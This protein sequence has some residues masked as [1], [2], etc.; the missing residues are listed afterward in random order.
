M[1][2]IIITAILTFNNIINQT[3]APIF[4]NSTITEILSPRLNVS[5]I[6]KREKHKIG[7]DFSI[8][9]QKDNTK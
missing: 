2:R 6:R 1:I 7:S 3:N 9:K 4:T 5:K 8:R